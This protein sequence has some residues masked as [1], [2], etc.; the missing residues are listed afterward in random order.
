MWQLGDTRFIGL[1]G[2][3]SF[4]AIRE[5]QYAEHPRAGV[6]ARLQRVGDKLEEINLALRL[7]SAF[8]IPEDELDKL[9]NSRQA[10]LIL[11]LVS[12]NGRYFGDFFIKSL[13]YRIE[14][15]WPDGKFQVLTIS[16]TLIEY[17]YDDRAAAERRK[18]RAGGFALPENASPL[19]VS[20]QAV[21]A[22]A[23]PAAQAVKITAALATARQMVGT[24]AQIARVASGP[25]NA[26]TLASV[27]FLLVT[28]SGETARLTA[29][30]I[31]TASVPASGPDTPPG[32]VSTLA[33]SI[34]APS[35][36]LS[37]AQT[38]SGVVGQVMAARA[39][40]APAPGLA[41][42]AAKR[43]AT[44]DAV[45]GLTTAANSLFAAVASRQATVT[46]WGILV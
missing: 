26:V 31:D 4:D 39:A 16:I 28:L 38:L 10:G 25:Q 2:F 40:G 14:S 20:P 1:A 44:E 45:K 41:D 11:G 7:H 33:E 13:N 36:A 21:P 42:V 19:P 9:E 24:L 30:L 34:T 29:G 32:M 5:T 35:G 43:T 18:V 12:A 6:K 23:G 46:D 27:G 8:C 17:Y 37:A 15:A 3:E 22:A